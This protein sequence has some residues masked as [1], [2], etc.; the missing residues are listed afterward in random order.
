MKCQTLT[1]LVLLSLL[2]GLAGCGEKATPT[3]PA[4][5]EL[6]VPADDVTLHVR[7]AGYPK[8]GDVLIAIHGGPGNS[9]DSMLSLEQLASGDCVVHLPLE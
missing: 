7:I 1:L 4:F 2:L 6:R 3:E 5:R 8:A 9:S